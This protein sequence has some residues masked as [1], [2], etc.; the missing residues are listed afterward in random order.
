MAV[1]E[2]AACSPRKCRKRLNWKKD[3]TKK[4]LMGEKE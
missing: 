3:S 2:L 4:V 1:D